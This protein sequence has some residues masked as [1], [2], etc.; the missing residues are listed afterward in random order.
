M[1]ILK[2]NGCEKGKNSKISLNSEI[3][4][5]LNKEL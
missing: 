4:I 1:Y 3:S 5:Y 2:G